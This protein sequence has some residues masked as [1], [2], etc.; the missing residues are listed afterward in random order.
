M[1][2]VF[3]DCGAH[4]GCSVRKFRKLYDP[5][6]NYEFHSFEP[7]S[8]TALDFNEPG[9]NFYQKAVTATGKVVPFFVHSIDDFACTTYRKKGILPNCGS[10]RA[11]NTLLQEVESVRLSKFIKDN[12]SPDDHIV[13]KLDI[14]GEEYN[15]IPDLFETGAI[16]LVNELYLEWHSHWMNESNEVDKELEEKIKNKG[17]ILINDWDA[18]DC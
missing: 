10:P 13:L 12:F 5:E 9:V 4:N 17:I 14:E 7:N 8:T 15:V 2:K 16:E 6:R 18:S 11:G 1:R 3:I